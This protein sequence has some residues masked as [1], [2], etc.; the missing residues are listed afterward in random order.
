MRRPVSRVVAGLFLVSA[1]FAVTAKPGVSAN[2]GCGVHVHTKTV[3]VT[4]CVTTLRPGVCRFAIHEYVRGR[5]TMLL[6][7]MIPCVRKG[8][9]SDPGDRRPL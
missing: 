3:L 5:E 9:L 2:L 8:E 1:L 7:R 6:T 4:T